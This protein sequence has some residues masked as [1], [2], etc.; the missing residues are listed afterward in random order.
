M[1]LTVQARATTVAMAPKGLARPRVLQLPAMQ[2]WAASCSLP[3]CSASIPAAT[4]QVPQDGAEL[5]FSMH[6]AMRPAGGAMQGGAA[7]WAP[8]PAQQAR[9]GA[10]AGKP[11]LL[12]S[13]AR[14]RFLRPCSRKTSLRAPTAPAPAWAPVLAPTAAAA[15][16]TG[17]AATAAGA[18]TGS[19]SPRGSAPP[20][21][22][23][24]R[25][26]Q[27]HPP[28]PVAAAAGAQ[29]TGQGLVGAGGGMLGPAAGAAGAALGALLDAAAS[30]AASSPPSEDHHFHGAPLPP[31]ASTRLQWAAAPGV[32]SAML[33]CGGEV[34]PTNWLIFYHD[35]ED[36]MAPPTPPSPSLPPQRLAAGQGQQG[37]PAAAPVGQA[38][39]EAAQA[40]K[41]APA[42]GEGKQQKQ[43]QQQS[44]RGSRWHWLLPWRWLG[45]GRRG[46]R[47][48]DTA[49]GAALHG[50]A[51]LKQAHQQAAAAAANLP[52]V[53]EGED[54][55]LWRAFHNMDSDRNG[56]I[57]AAELRVA[58]ARLGLPASQE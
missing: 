36:L 44:S 24:P 58:L 31:P 17:S 12:L 53:P 11:P 43:Q 6:G 48:A 1:G 51:R 50:P 52:A 49:S 39:G 56:V 8:G 13:T 5:C 30:L 32:Y 29:P 27:G 19:S 2:A 28:Q 33:A 37:A 38:G 26:G 10:S 23:Q 14:T 55:A 42:Q 46:G 15:A 7:A 21:H 20:G 18:A 47:A 45:L 41:S 22:E 9:Q 4:T 54:R 25:P 35:H 16:A 40:S 3:T 57:D 34:G